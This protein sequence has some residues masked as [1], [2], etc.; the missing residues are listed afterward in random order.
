MPMRRKEVRLRC[1]YFCVLS[2]SLLGFNL[3]IILIG[4]RTPWDPGIMHEHFSRKRD[5]PKNKLPHE[6]QPS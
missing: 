4:L 2:L 5:T 1:Y 6:L 3:A